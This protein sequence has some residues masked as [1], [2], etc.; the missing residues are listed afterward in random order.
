MYEQVKKIR[1]NSYQLN[2][3]GNN[4]GVKT[5]GNKI[6][7]MDSQ[8]IGQRKIIDTLDIEMYRQG[9]NG[10]APTYTITQNEVQGG[11]DVVIVGGGY[12]TPDE[13]IHIANVNP[14]MKLRG[15]YLNGNGIR[16]IIRNQMNQTQVQEFNNALLGPHPEDDVAAFFAALDARGPLII[17]DN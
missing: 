6:K 1:R 5:V 9:H 13:I 4:F 7:K 17:E 11:D 14:N 3:S 8:T 16:D 2:S 10:Q 12:Y 15:V